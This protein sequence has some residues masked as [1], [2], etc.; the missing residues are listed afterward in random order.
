MLG[1]PKGLVLKRFSQNETIGTYQMKSLVCTPRKNQP[2][3]TAR[4]S[5]I[6]IVRSVSLFRILRSLT[7]V[8]PSTSCFSSCE[9]MCANPARMRRVPA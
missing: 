7:I 4:D 6:M 5:K 8:S 3:G 1:R 2:H 9:I